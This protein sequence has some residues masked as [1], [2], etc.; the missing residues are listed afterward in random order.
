MSYLIVIP[1]YNE[2]K[3]IKTLLNRISSITRDIVVVDDGSEDATYRIVK[4]MGI[5]VL[6]QEH[7][8][9]GAALKAGFKYA[10][11]KG[12]KWVITMD[13]DGQHEWRDIF[14][15]IEELSRGNG[16]IIVGSRMADIATMPLIRR[17][18]NRF[19]S[20]LISR[21]IGLRI[22]D[23]QCGFRAISSQVLKNI[24]LETAH[25]DTESELL[26]KAGK[27]RYT[28]S[29]IPIKTIYNGSQGNI[30]KFMD[31]LRFIKLVWK[32]L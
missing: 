9:K 14:R 16:D 20:G 32:T 24:R 8:G 2:E 29:S 21:L 31:T 5:S 4:E 12:Y 25:Y 3:Y 19:M 26:I 1:A 13:G 17:I 23:T 11:E 15:F 22:S 30:S 27:A 7:K 28:I 18:T 6:H 10:V